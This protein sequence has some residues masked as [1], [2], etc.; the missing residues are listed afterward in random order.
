MFGHKL[1]SLNECMIVGTGTIT[2]DNPVLDCRLD[3]LSNRSP[4]IFILDEAY[5]KGNLKYLVKIEKFMYF[6]LIK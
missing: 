1:R 2:K 6:I 4:D 3:G 5:F